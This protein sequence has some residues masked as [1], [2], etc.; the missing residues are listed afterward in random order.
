MKRFFLVLACLVLATGPLLAEK[1]R[2]HQLSP[3]ATV[4]ISGNPLSIVVGDDTAMQV[5]NSAVVSNPPGS[6]QF[7]PGDTVAGETAESGVF[8]H[9]SGGLVYGPGSTGVGTAFTPV[10]LSPVTGTGT[11]G[12]PFTVVVVV[13]IPTTS[14]QLT[15]TLTYV[16]GAAQANIA[17]SF[18]GNG[19]P[20][21]DLDAFIAADLYLA[22]NDRGFSFATTASA[23][24]NAA[25]TSCNPLQYTIAFLGT[26]PAN[27]F[28]ANGYSQVWSEVEAGNL[29]NTF[30][31]SCIDNGAALEWTGL[32]V[33]AAP[34]VINTAA[35]FT[36]QLVPQ[37]QAE[38]PTLS[39]AGIAALVLLLAVVGFVLAKRTSLGA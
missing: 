15:E 17:L 27:R 24:G 2:P 37:Q 23:G 14:V 10:S 12:D 32:A 19:N 26:T 25:D 7:Y 6:G 9:P 20:V 36:G 5:Y 4:T 22:G 28:T 1:N 35:S 33:G 8:V 29:S 31:P 30:T 3:L 21:V 18:V 38:V 16:N 34:V 11:A 13:D 39:A